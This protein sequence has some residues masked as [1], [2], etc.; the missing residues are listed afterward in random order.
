MTGFY[1][2]GEPFNMQ[3]AIATAITFLGVF[4][5][6]SRG[7]GRKKGIEEAESDIEPPIQLGG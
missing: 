6:T 1:L 5:A 4:L 3:M 7:Y 2:L